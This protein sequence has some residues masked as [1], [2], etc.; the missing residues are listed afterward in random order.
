MA[1]NAK[2]LLAGW[3]SFEVS[4]SYVCPSPEIAARH[5]THGVGRG[6]SQETMAVAE[7]LS[8][9][10]FC[11]PNGETKHV[12]TLHTYRSYGIGPLSA[13]HFQEIAILGRS[14]QGPFGSLFG[15]IQSRLFFILLL[16]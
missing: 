15:L 14:A 2:L 9:N 7:R 5:A 8:S 12:G 13:R 3:A 4:L 6:C 16:G 11:T 10:S 1:S